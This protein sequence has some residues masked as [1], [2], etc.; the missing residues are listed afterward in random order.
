VPAPKGE[1]G[2]RK[3]GKKENE[4]AGDGSALR[5]HTLDQGSTAEEG[6]ELNKNESASP[7]TAESKGSGESVQK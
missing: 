3:G 6:A 1:E 2:L 5:D 4:A 7:V